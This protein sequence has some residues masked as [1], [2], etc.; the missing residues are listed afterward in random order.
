MLILV[1]LLSCSGGP[2]PV[3]EVQGAGPAPLE[4][5]KLGPGAE[6]DGIGRQVTEIGGLLAE[7]PALVVD[8]QGRVWMAWVE[9]LADGERLL[10][11]QGQE[12]PRVIAQ[13]DALWRPVLA[14]GEDGSV[15]MAWEQGAQPRRVLVQRVD[16]A[17]EVRELCSSSTWC[18]WPDLAVA[19]DGVAH[20]VW[21]EA[22]DRDTTRIAH[23]ALGSG[24][25]TVAEGFLLRRPSIVLDGTEVV[26][27]WDT[28]QTG[29]SAP[30]LHRSFPADPDY[31]VYVAR[32][33]G[34]WSGPAVLAGGEGIQAAPDLAM[35]AEGV[36]VAFHD[37]REHGLVK[38]WVLRSLDG[39]E[40]RDPD[41]RAL[42]TGE[43]QGAEFPALAI[44]PKGAAA[45]VTRSSQGAYLHI[46]DPR[47]V[48]GPYD[49]TRSGWGARGIR[50]ALAVGPEGTL[51]ALRRARKSLVLETFSGLAERGRV[52]LQPYGERGSGYRVE[53]AQAPVRA[54]C[55]R[56]VWGDVH[57]HSAL[58][59]GT[60]TPDEILAR[61]WARGLD[62][63]VLSD[64]DN[65][66][67]SRMFPGE[68]AELM[69][70]TD[71]LDRLDGFTTLH[72]YEW[73][74][75]PTPKGSGHQIAYFAERPPAVY[76]YRDVAPDLQ[77]LN[78][79]LSDLEVF[80]AP[81]HSTWTGTPWQDYDPD[82]QRQVEIVSVHGLAESPNQEHIEARGEVAGS[83]AVE[84]L[85]QGLE[86]GFMGGSDAHGLLWHHGMARRRDPWTQGLTGT[87]CSEP[88]TR[89][90]LFQG[91]Y[92]R[93]SFATSGPPMTALLWSG[94]ARMGDSIQAGSSVRL[95]W[96]VRGTR[97]L[98]ELVIVRDGE[99][100]HVQELQG[101][102]AEGNFTDEPGAGSHSYYLR[103]LQAPDAESVPD[104][105]WSSPLFVEV[106]K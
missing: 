76:G 25:S 19:R 103:V 56:V 66:V 42:P 60:G 100:I 69:W 58:S 91:L 3:A 16:E 61:A 79:K 59:D 80:T 63:A 18:G 13:G 44:L 36:L 65:I 10:V 55:G 23:Q 21:E 106:S 64:H 43:Q 15:W 29:R 51:Y 1:P 89:S 73:T 83:T 57:M 88:C 49:L 96:R 94:P 26:V 70:V 9:L 47:G 37:S 102:E 2:L 41:E 77:S 85:G 4:V 12:A 32:W 67:G 82:I 75:P 92:G 17:A 6:V 104:L 48:H 7:S 45:I 8:S 72:A 95:S 99:T 34:A 53:P 101:L 86:F 93:H 50:A 52:P 24:P 40:L 105:A 54:L 78:E 5:Q 98:Q 33:A 74:T 39:F 35:G 84:G 90:S 46:A 38:W 81:H 97:E 87:L 14:A 31:D 11:Q 27:A 68:H 62:F 22:L 71:K 30:G 20:V 28:L